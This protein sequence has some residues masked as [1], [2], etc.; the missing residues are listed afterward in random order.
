MKYHFISI[1][2]ILGNVVCINFFQC[3]VMDKR[4]LTVIIKKELSKSS[5]LAGNR[6]EFDII[7][8]RDLLGMKELSNVS[9]F[10][11]GSIQPDRSCYNKVDFCIE[12]K[13]LER[14]F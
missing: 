14:K 5:I 4:E 9:L 12:K 11:R 10:L 8:Y 13:S 7:P 6:I 2:N 1:Q 3:A